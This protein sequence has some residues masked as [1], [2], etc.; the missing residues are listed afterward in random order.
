MDTDDKEVVHLDDF[1]N[2]TNQPGGK[3]YQSYLDLV[4]AGRRTT[5]MTTVPNSKTIPGT[6]KTRFAVVQVLSTSAWITGAEATNLLKQFG[7]LTSTVALR[8]CL[9]RMSH[10]GYVE[11]R[12]RVGDR[13]GRREWKLT[14]VGLQL[15][16]NGTPPAKIKIPTGSKGSQ[17]RQATMCI[18]PNKTSLNAAIESV[19]LGLMTDS[20]TFSAHDV[21]KELRER[22]SKGSV[23]LDLAETGTVHIHG[24]DVAK[25]EHD[26]VRDATHEL[27][28]QGKM[29]GYVRNHNGNYWTYAPAPAASPD[30][31]PATP[32]PSPSTPPVASGSYDGS[33]T[34]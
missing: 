12:K 29:T 34:L 4:N 30:P 33:S 20:K 32:D 15:S 5:G 2:P 10:K 17:G 7:Y 24:V 25:V 14:P 21:T 16:I 1:D 27:F 22:V 23:P 18:D 9:S 11:G 26:Y 28:H 19:V 3:A 8:P 6:T 31:D 13:Y